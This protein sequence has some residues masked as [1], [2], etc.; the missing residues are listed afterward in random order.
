M[1]GNF[2]IFAACSVMMLGLNSCDLTGLNDNPNQPTDKVDYN[3]NEPRLASTL[4]GGMIIDGNIE[5]RLKALQIDFYSQMVVDGSG[6]WKTRNYIQ[7]DGW[8]TGAWQEYLKQI[9]SLNIV[10]RSL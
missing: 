6:R 10:I 2:K 7:D 5:K 3:M 9:A 4:R 1:K 8:N